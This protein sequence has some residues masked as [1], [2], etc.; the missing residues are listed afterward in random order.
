MTIFQCL[1]L[2]QFKRP[3]P[4]IPSW[5]RPDSAAP[6]RLCSSWTM[7]KCHPCTLPSKC[8]SRWYGLRAWYDMTWHDLTWHD[9]TWLDDDSWFTQCDS[10]QDG[11]GRGLA[12]AEGF[13]PE[14]PSDFYRNT[15]T[16][17]LRWHVQ[18]NTMKYIC[19]Q[20]HQKKPPRLAAGRPGHSHLPPKD[21]RNPACTAESRW[22]CCQ[23]W[24]QLANLKDSNCTGTELTVYLRGGHACCL[25][26][27][28]S[29]IGTPKVNQTWILY[30]QLKTDTTTDSVPCMVWR[31]LPFRCASVAGP[32]RHQSP[33]PSEMLGRS[34]SRLRPGAS[35]NFRVSCS[36]GKHHRNP[37]L[38]VRRQC[39]ESKLLVH[40]RPRIDQYN[41]MKIPW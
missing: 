19:R 18:R 32:L 24:H 3:T 14:H 28:C 7:A 25:S 33:P 6:R 40:S 12:G 11:A 15:Q 13:P 22:F 17:S 31:T 20:R 21:R 38:S 8:R 26:N 34:L 29:E 41:S 10:V 36:S 9:L 16:V 1:F 37:G 35:R 23:Q 5:D 2:R 4:P 39:L 30:I 27:Q